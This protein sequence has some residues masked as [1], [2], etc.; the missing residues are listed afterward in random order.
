MSDSCFMMKP[1]RGRV[2]K[3]EESKR[4]SRRR[5]WEEGAQAVTLLHRGASGS[6]SWV[7]PALVPMARP[8]LGQWPR[9]PSNSELSQWLGL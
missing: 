2:Q 9:P 7:T 4:P 5:G 1:G 3:E 6:D 8:L